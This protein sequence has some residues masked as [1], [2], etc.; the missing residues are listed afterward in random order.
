MSGTSMETPHVAG[1]LALLYEADPKFTIE[2]A[3]DGPSATSPKSDH[4]TC[5]RIFDM[6]F[7]ESLS[8][9]VFGSGLLAKNMIRSRSRMPG[10]WLIFCR[11]SQGL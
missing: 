6:I 1:V 10:G 11:T 4:D 2:R 8:P 3:C 9:N 7:F 5:L